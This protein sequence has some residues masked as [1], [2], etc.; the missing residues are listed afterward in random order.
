M[1]IFNRMPVI[2]I[3]FG[4]LLN[5]VGVVAYVFTDMQHKTALIPCVFGLL[6]LVCGVIARTPAHLKHA[7]HAAAMI[8]LL[9]LVAGG[10]RFVMGLIKGA[11]GKEAALAATGT[12][13]LLCGLYV[14]CCVKSFIAAKKA[15]LAA[16]AAAGN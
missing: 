4:I 6:I 14:F 16:E 7:M 5:I 15:R 1:N 11:Q 13:A 8:G 2:S 9:G 10:G 3:I 12:M